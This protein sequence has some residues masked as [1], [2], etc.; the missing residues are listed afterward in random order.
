MLLKS[1]ESDEMIRLIKDLLDICLQ[2]TNVIIRE[3]HMLQ[4]VEA[5]IRNCVAAAAK[6]RWKEAEL[7]RIEGRLQRWYKKKN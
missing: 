6:P 1:R 5:S 4:N 7:E 3:C 2:P